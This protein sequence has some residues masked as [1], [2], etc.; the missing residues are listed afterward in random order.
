M[1]RFAIIFV[2]LVVLVLGP[3][4]IWGDR[5]EGL[6]S[7]DGAVAEIEKYGSWAWIAGVVLLVADIAIPVP[8]GAVMGALGVIYGPVWGALFAFIG[9]SLAGLTGYGIGRV[10]GRPVTKRLLGDAATERGETLFARSGGWLVALSRWMPVL[11]EVIACIAGISRMR[12]AAFVLALISGTLPLSIVFAGIGHLGAETP[13]VTLA[14]CAVAP[15]IIWLVLDRLVLR[16]L[17]SGTH[18]DGVA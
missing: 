10:F 2:A 15:V 8:A 5:L 16:R 17:W 6:F 14:I 18:D 13:L 1:T 11:P 4:L 7:G 3:F 9:T 12:F